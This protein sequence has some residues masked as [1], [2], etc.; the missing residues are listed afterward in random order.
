MAL[1]RASLPTVAPPASAADAVY[2]LS[3]RT[4]C[5]EFGLGLQGADQGRTERLLPDRDGQPRS[6]TA[7]RGN[8]LSFPEVLSLEARKPDMCAEL[9]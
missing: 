8:V 5:A 3:A 9:S 6:I 7:G 4:A 1:V 2:D